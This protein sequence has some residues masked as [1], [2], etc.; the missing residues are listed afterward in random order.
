VSL[1][2]PILTSFVVVALAEMG[3]KTQLLAFSLAS[4]YRKPWPIMA[5]ILSATLVNHALSAWGGSWAATRLSPRVLAWIL[6]ASFL[7]FAAWTLVP[8]R[9]DDDRSDRGFGPYATTAVTFF[10]VEIGDKT[11][12]ATMALGA[13]FGNPLA[14][15]IGTTAGMLVADGL[16][17]FA[18]DRLGEK[19]PLRWL[20]M[21]TAALFLAFGIASF[22]TALR[23]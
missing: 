17:V 9:Y 19:L 21:L 10:L 12:L 13:R 7:G 5:G 2:E 15:T 1:G 11:Q 3:D 22:V 6:T 16:G 4:R 23:L 20:R 14:I 8:D 18:G